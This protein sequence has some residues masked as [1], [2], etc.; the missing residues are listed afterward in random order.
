ME[1]TMDFKTLWLLF[2]SHLRLILALTVAGAAVAGAVTVFLITPKYTSKA[3]LYVENKEKTSETLDINEINAAQKLVE[4]CVIIFE[5]D[6]VL[7]GVKNDLRLDYSLREL[8]DMIVLAPVKTSAVMEISVESEDPDEAAAIAAGVIERGSELFREVVRSGSIELVDP[9]SAP[10]AP[11]SPSLRVN[12]LIGLLGGFFLAAGIT[13]FIGL[14]DTSVKAE[15][16]LQKI[17]D[18]PV[19]AEIPAP[20]KAKKAG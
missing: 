15:D 11:S 16:D 4:T 5:S 14:F 8:A 10:E 12:L 9:A 2:V 7:S 3:K 1:K 17:Y 19:F 18:I 13:V 6:T 20:E